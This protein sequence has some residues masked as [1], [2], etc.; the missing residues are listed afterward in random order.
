MTGKIDMRRAQNRHDSLSLM[1][2]L[3]LIGEC[4]CIQFRIPSSVRL[5]TNSSLPISCYDPS[6]AMMDGGHG[7]WYALCSKNKNILKVAIA[8]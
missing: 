5:N 1:L 6:A 2:T 7:D 3:F 4:H 8:R